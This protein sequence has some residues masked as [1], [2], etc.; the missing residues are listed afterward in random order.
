MLCNLGTRY[1]PSGSRHGAVLA[2]TRLAFPS[3]ARARAWVADVLSKLAWWCD[4]GGTHK[5]GL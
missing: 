1:A 4:P 3:M 5:R 2:V